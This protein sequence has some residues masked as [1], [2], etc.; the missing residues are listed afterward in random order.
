MPRCFA[1]S[2]AAAL[3]LL[4]SAPGHA[5]T[6]PGDPAQPAPPAPATTPAEPPPDAT[7]APPPPPASP[8]ATAAPAPSNE[9]NDDTKDHDR[10][11]G[12]LAV[13]Y[14]GVTSV[15][16]ANPNGTAS[17]LSAPVLGVRY[18]ISKRL[19]LDIGVG[20]GVRGGSSETG[21]TVVDS[22]TQTGFLL[23]V[24]V[25][26]SLYAGEHSSFQLVPEAHGGMAF[27]TLTTPN[28]PDVSLSGNRMD[29]GAR[30]GSEIHFGFID[31]PELALQGSVGL[32]FRRQGWSATPD[33]GPT[34]GGSQFGIATSVQG[35]PW[36]IFTNNI[37]ALYYF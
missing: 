9:D 33:G 36:A 34:S 19:G 1:T 11:V 7:A 28:N 6:S 12:H 29:V 35:D 15:P 32:Y 25:P 14:F 31:V 2:V 37:S 22:P 4:A 10:F 26:L 8:A 24:G 3:G 17:S 23:H 20:I 5:Q 30:I 13:G 21:G 27:T 18:W 16:L